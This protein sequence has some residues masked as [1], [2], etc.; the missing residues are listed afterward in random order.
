MS[1]IRLYTLI[2]FGQVVF[3]ATPLFIK[4]ALRDFD[5]FTFGIIR[6]VIS[7]ILLNLF[8]LIIGKPLI[9]KRK[10]WFWVALLGFLAIPANQGLLFIG[11]EYTTPGHS[12]LLYGLTPI[13]VYL[14]AIPILKERFIFKKLVGILMAFAGVVIILL[15]RNITIEPKFATGD[16]IIFF[17]VI[18][19]AL[20]TVFG[21]TLVKRLGSILAITYTMTF[22]TLIFLPIGAYNTISFSY[23]DVTGLS[24]VAVLFTAI[25]TSGIA[26]PV[27]YWALKYME[28]S[29]L[30]VF[31]YFQPILATVLSY[32][33]LAEQ[34][35]TNFVVG[36][37][38][39][40]MGVFVAER[41][42]GK[43][44]NVIEAP[45]MT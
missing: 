28:A 45:D 36:G 12:A 10:D 40:L 35:T 41:L 44:A 16:I 34:L 17:G 23:A 4:I 3:S 15:D 42:N 38:V 29:K 33:F 30:S 13:L 19:W 7:V 24:W 22:G 39:V 14:F 5:P 21:K 32:I 27:W 8:L 26:Y 43:R 20:Y 1:A 18:A 2:I 31:I 9:P 25:I 37:I 11:L 6:F